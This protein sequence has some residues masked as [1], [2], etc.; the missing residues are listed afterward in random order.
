MAAVLCEVLEHFVEL[1]L[2]GLVDVK[3]E[4]AEF[5]FKVVH[6]TKVIV[7]TL[8]VRLE[9][10]FAQVTAFE[11]FMDG[12]GTET[13][14]SHSGCNATTCKRVRMM[15]GIT[16]EGEAVQ[17]VVFEHARNWNGS[18]DNVIDFGT[19]EELVEPFQRGVQDVLAVLS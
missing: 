18:S 12:L 17:R 3:Q 7:A 16:H 19:R 5:I 6:A 14:G 13:S 8:F 2:V 15:G 4:P 1:C 11:A 10:C 9:K